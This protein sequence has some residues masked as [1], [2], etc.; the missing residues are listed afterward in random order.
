MT[1]GCSFLMTRLRRH[2]AVKSISDFGARG[3]S[4]SP[5]AARLRSS[6]SGCATS[7]ARWPISRSPLTVSR[8]WFCPPR[9]VLAVSMCSENIVLEI[10]QFLEFEGN[11]LRVHAGNHQ[12]GPAVHESALQDV[13]AEEGKLRLQGEVE[14]CR[15]PTLFEH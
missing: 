8:T 4:S 2:A 14:G 5:S 7:A 11:V 1:S 10:A 9:Q 13:V 6:P 3:T 12:A 15:A